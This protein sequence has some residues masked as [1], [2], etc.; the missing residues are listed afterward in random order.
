ME[1]SPLNADSRCS[2]DEE[3]AAV[4]R[5][6]VRRSRQWALSS[7]TSKNT[8]TLLLY[9]AFLYSPP[10]YAL[11]SQDASSVLLR[12]TG[13]ILYAFPSYFF[14]ATRSIHSIFLNLIILT[15]CEK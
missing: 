13:L 5:R 11:V 1:P 14:P 8:R 4:L 15:Y 2:A 12:L 3:N 9:D 7:A 10:T 6:R